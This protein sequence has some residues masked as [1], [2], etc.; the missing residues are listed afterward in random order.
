MKIYIH[1][2]G[3][4]DNIEDRICAPDHYR[5]KKGGFFGALYFDFFRDYDFQ[6]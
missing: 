1:L 3:K 5:E 6:I 4:V 2:L